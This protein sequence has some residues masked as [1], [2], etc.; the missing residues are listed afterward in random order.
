MFN[1]KVKG[2]LI[3]NDREFKLNSSFRWPGDANCLVVRAVNVAG[4]IFLASL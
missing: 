4:G 1:G 3:V 2:I